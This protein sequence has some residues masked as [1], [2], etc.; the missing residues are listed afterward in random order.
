LSPADTADLETRYSQL[1]QAALHAAAEGQ[2]DVSFWSAGSALGGHII[3]EGRFREFYV[4][5]TAYGRTIWFRDTAGP[6]G[7]FPR[8]RLHYQLTQ[9]S[10]QGA[11]FQGFYLDEGQPLRPPQAV[12]LTTLRETCDFWLD[13]LAATRDSRVAAAGKSPADEASFATVR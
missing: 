1:F 2:S 12:A 8:T 5:E 9:G 13:L 7:E 6:N 11:V 10:Q 4:S 3:H